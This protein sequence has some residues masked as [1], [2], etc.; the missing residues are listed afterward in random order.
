MY[1][2]SYLKVVYKWVVRI[3]TKIPLVK[4]VKNKKMENRLIDVFKNESFLRGKSV[5]VFKSL[6]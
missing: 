1:F 3:N 5:E 4:S 6:C 2:T